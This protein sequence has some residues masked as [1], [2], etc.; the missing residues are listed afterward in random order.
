MR[1][2]TK[3]RYGSRFMLE[4]AINYNKG[5]MLLKEI[6]KRQELSEGYLQHI[7]DSLKGARL[8][9][10]NRVGH[11]GYTLVRP[12]SE[13]T[14]LEILS[15]LEGKINLVECVDKPDICSRSQ[16]CVTRDIWGDL[17]SQMTKSLK[18]ITLESMVEK[19]KEKNS[20]NIDYAI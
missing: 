9:H 15:S 18:S 10:S 19:N 20:N 8:I 1:I 16:I 3:G 5:P 17:G 12:P 14:L 6:A 2:S 7:V 11:G 4:L 13:I